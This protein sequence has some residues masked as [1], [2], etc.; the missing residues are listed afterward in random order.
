[1]ASAF[2]QYKP[3]VRQEGFHLPSPPPSADTPPPLHGHDGSNIFGSMGHA[4]IGDFNDEL[5]SLIG[6]SSERST[7]TQSPV[8]Y[9]NNHD[10]SSSSSNG[11]DGYRPPPHTHNI[12]DISAP[13]QHQHSASASS[14]SS[15]P[16]HF[17]LPSSSTPHNNNNG[18]GSPNGSNGHEPQP[19]HFNSTLPALNSS[20]RYDPHPPPSSAGGGAGSYGMASPSSF[21]SPSPHAQASRSRSRSR[22][23]SSHL[24]QQRESCVSAFA[25]IV[26]DGAAA[27]PAGGPTRTTRARRN[28]SL[29]STSPPPRP[30]P[31]AIVIP[32]GHGESPPSLVIFFFLHSLSCVPHFGPCF[33][34]LRRCHTPLHST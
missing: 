21:R 22:P 4:G 5:A 34:F 3:H 20:M 27:T 24:A 6:Q 8:G 12:F 16:S 2:A 9:N 25:L 31:Q 30:V 11:G 28:G 19:Y 18:G 17:S 29:S 10:G 1:M 14:T 32:S 13:H 23:P 7:H 15:F 26:N 33:L